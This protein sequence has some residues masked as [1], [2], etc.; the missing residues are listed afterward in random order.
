MELAISTDLREGWPVHAQDSF[1]A[2]CRNGGIVLSDHAAS[3]PPVKA[4]CCYICL[5]DPQVQA[6]TGSFCRELTSG[7]TKKSLTYSLT[8]SL[9]A[10][11]KIVYQTSPDRIEIAIAADEGLHDPGRIAG[12]IDQLGCWTIAE[13]LGPNSEPVGL[14]AAIQEFGRENVSIR[15]APT[16]S[17]DRSDG[18]C[19][20]AGGWPD[21]D[22]GQPVYSSGSVVNSSG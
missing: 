16:C 7:L 6:G 2:C 14:D 9:R 10:D 17:M 22:V 15:V 20:L 8:T 12:N 13:P 3:E 21:S 5:E 19:V 18:R 11:V 1:S 4:K